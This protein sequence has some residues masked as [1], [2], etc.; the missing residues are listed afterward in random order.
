MRRLWPFLAIAAAAALIW[1]PTLFVSQQGDS[2][3]YDL[4][5]SAQ[6]ARLAGHGVLYPRWMP[7]SFSGLG[8]PTFYFYP[9]LG[10]WVVAL[11]NAAGAG[12][13]APLV[14]LRLA[15]LAI[16]AASGWTMYLWLRTHA[17]PP[18]A[19]ICAAAFMLAPYHVDDHYLRAAFA[20]MAAIAVVPLV[21][22]GLA[23]TAEGRRFGPVWL[24]VGW[25]ALILAHLPIALLTGV[26]LVAPYGLFLVWRGRGRRRAF[27]ARAGCAL[28]LGTGLAA[29]YLLPALTLQGFISADYWAHAAGRFGDQLFANPH[30][31]SA[32]PIPFFAAISLAEAGVAAAVAWRAWARRDADALFWAA[33][34]IGLFLVMAG[35]VPG[36]WSLPLMTEVQFPWRAMALQEFALVTLLA[37]APAGSGPLPSLIFGVLVVANLIPIGQFSF[38]GAPSR[39]GYAATTFPTDAD[40]PEYLPHGMLVVTPQGPAPRVGFQQLSAL[41]LVSEAGTAAARDPLSGAV[42]IDVAPGPARPIVVRQFYFPSWRARCDGREAEV[43]AAGAGR[44]IGFTVPA[45]ARSCD[46]AIRPPMPQRLGERI[47]LVSLIL[48]ALYSLWAVTRPRSSSPR[49]E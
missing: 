34:V 30:A 47:S 20:E 13:L 48:I 9:P 24:A 22:L 17:E 2:F 35:L 1:A 23:R 5:W 12:A 39:P 46:L 8:S 37:W 36:F 40:A 14:Q 26:L 10:F 11:V 16:I 19:L 7:A 29:L 41:P 43:T 44:L 42:H 4:N 21:G 38:G 27:V 49:R 25:G 45:S 31:W 33:C 15:E 28:A 18:R 3:G 32:P 6:F